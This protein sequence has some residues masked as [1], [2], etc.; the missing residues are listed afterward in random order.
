MIKTLVCLLLAEAAVAAAAQ[1]G[2]T[3][4]NVKVSVSGRYCADLKDVY[5][6][7]NGDD[8][9]ERWVKLDHDK[10]VQCVWTKDLGGRTISTSVATFS[11]RAGT[12][13][14][15]C[16]KAD[17]DEETLLAT[18]GKTLLANINFSYSK[19]RTFRNVSVKTVP[20]MPVSY[21]RYV[22]PFDAGANPT[23][24]REAAAFD[25]G[26]GAISNTTFDGEK[27][28]FDFGPLN[29]KRQETG[30]ILNDIV[31][32]DG[33]RILTLDGVVYRLTAQRAQ[34]KVRSAPSLSP[35]AI[36]LDIK[37]LGDLKFE[38][39]EFQVIK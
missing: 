27:I 16:Q 20:P 5:L 1:G 2:I 38:R 10:R 8:R 26:Q 39:A 6:V 14:S 21:V 29:A 15:G 13:R 37:K 30:L 17:P 22:R 35:N 36:S 34:G 31:V 28:H 19:E 3:T 24:C 25:H 4:A 9:E 23:P 32:D 18:D 12:M 11:L 7:I 33:V